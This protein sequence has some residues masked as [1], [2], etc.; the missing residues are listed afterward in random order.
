M[1][2]AHSHRILVVTPTLGD[3]PFLGHT[4]A[5]VTA[6]PLDIL[7]VMVTPADKVAALQ[8]R[9]PHARVCRDGGK[10]GGVYGALNAA[11]DCTRGAWDWF[12]YINDDD[13]LLP[14]FAAM[15]SA[16]CDAS[17]TPDV[18]YGDVEL[19]DENGRRVSRVTIERNPAWIPALLQ[20]GISPLM[21][22]GMLFRRAVVE[23]LQGFDTRYRLCADLDFWLRAYASGACFRS[24]RERVGQFRLRGGQLSANTALTERE[25]AAIVAR[26]LPRA[27]SMLRR[28]SAR[29]RYRWCNLPRYIGRLRRRGFHTSYELLQTEEANP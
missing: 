5:T 20:Q 7:H 16:E 14:G 11:L 6:Q 3:S 17:P 1:T 24:G 8:I 12:T 23:R 29:W 26:H 18:I 2:T 10:T 4:V 9:F 28:G 21:Q 13:A 22:Q 19:V 25:Q 27:V 15:V